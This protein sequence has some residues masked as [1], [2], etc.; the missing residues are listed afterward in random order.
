M[1]ITKEMENTAD[2]KEFPLLS[3]APLLKWIREFVQA[4]GCTISDSA[5]EELLQMVGEDQW[6]LDSELR[7]ICLFVGSGDI[8]AEHVDLLAVPSGTQIV[9]KLTDLICGGKALEAMSFL[10]RRL[11]RGEDPYGIWTI[12]MNMVKN[13]TLVTAA[14]QEGERDE[15][16]IASATGIHFFAVRGILPLARKLDLKKIN[17]IVRFVVEMDIALKSGGIKYTV[18]HPDEVIGI[19]E[20]VILMCK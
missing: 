4:K 6:I 15:R 16:G 20:R 17:Q 12:L 7:K 1:T 10:R 18:E 13:L 8:M 11:E 2:V 9:W 5:M 14:L 3:R 19:S